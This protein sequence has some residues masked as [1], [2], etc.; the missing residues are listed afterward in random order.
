MEFG[1]QD[2]DIKEIKT[3]FA[4]FRNI[5]QVVLFGSRALGR[6][7]PGSDI[8]FA[9]SGSNLTFNEILEISNRLEDLGMFYS[10]DIQNMASIK[11]SALIDHIQRVGKVFYKA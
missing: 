11:D 2:N 7:K 9:I 3:V 6:H 4:S 1:L 8:D 5:D 10:F